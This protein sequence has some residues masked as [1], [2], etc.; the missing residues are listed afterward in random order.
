MWTWYLY[1]G[2][3]PSTLDHP[4]LPYFDFDQVKQTGLDNHEQILWISNDGE[5][6][7]PIELAIG[8]VANCVTVLSSLVLPSC[9]C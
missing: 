3:S 2:L 6:V 1:R 5:F 7:R 4:S 8:P 9:R